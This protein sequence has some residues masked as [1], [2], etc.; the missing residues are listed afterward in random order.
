MDR[1]DAERH[2]PLRGFWRA[3]LWISAGIAGAVAVPGLAMVV[4]AWWLPL[5]P[6]VILLGTGVLLIGI[7][8]IISWQITNT[9]LDATLGADGTLTLRRLGREMRTHATR[10]QQVRFSAL[11]SK[12]H[13]P[14]VIETAEGSVTFLHPRREVDELI[15]A[16]HRYNPHFPVQL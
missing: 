9:V 8:S 2:W 10:V 1:Y 6:R 3:W 5:P 15:A 7:A 16:L 14:I 11:V 12:P 4:L 13:T